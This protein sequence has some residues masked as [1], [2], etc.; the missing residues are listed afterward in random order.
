MRKALKIAAA[1]IVTGLILAQFFRPD[2]T[3]PP[4]VQAETLQSST[5]VPADVQAVL[6]RSCSD[7]HSNNT[8]YPWYSNISPFSWFLAD[9]I[10]E[11]RREMNL[12]VWNTYGPEKKS[13]KLEEICK[14]VE[15]K[16]MPLPSYL[17]LHRDAVLT[18]SEAKLLCDWAASEKASIDKTILY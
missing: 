1:V 12:S 6:A 14:Q 10:E 18:E 2:R 11:G 17:W 16:E 5:A 4:V 13:K 9:H 3:N 7:C 8:T 15:T